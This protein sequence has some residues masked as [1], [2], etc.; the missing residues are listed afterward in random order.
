MDIKESIDMALGAMRANKMRSVLTMLGIVIG[1]MTVIGMM[2]I[3]KGLS[4]SFDEQLNVLGSNVFQVQKFPA[5]NTGRIPKSIR[6]RKPLK[7][8]HAYFVRDNAKTVKAVGPELWR[9]GDVIKHGEHKTNPDVQIS[10]GTPEFSVSN[11]YFVKSG[12]FLTDEDIHIRRNV[13]VLGMD[14]VNKV[15]PYGDPVGQTV[16]IGADRYEVIGVYEE[17]GKSFGQSQDNIVTIPVSTFYKYYGD[18]RGRYHFTVQVKDGVNINDSIE[19]VTN[20]LRI[21]RKVPPDQPNDFEIFTSETLIEAFNNLTFIIKVVAIGICSISLLVGG[22]GI[23]NI[24]LVSVTER[25][26]EIGIRKALGARRRDI[27]LQFLIEA[28]VLSLIGGVMGVIVGILV[29]KTVSWTTPLPASIP[30]WA[31]FLALGFSSLVGLFF[32]IWP[33]SRAAKLDPIE[34]LRYE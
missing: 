4:D 24:M 11:G 18:T 23:M 32:G 13:A 21:V 15:F 20:L 3:I 30:V 27:L 25:T 28:V 33:A 2:S 22:I 19:E 17:K 14:V 12:R 10:G 34:S 26:K 6:N 8:E 16:R 7:P 31:V 5:I 29:G 1:V 9:F